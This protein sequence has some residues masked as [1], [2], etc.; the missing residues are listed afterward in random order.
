MKKSIIAIA[1]AALMLFVGQTASAQLYFGGSLG[2]TSTTRK[3]GQATQSGASFKFLPEVG[4]QINDRMSVGGVVGY[5]SGYAALGS[6][7]PTDLKSIATAAVSTSVDLNSDPN[8]LTVPGQA[9]NGGGNRING[10]RIAP[11]FRFNIF[12][13]RRFDFFVEGV[14]ALNSITMK[15]YDGQQWQTGGEYTLIEFGAKPGFKIKFDNH[16]NI[17]GRLG[18][19]GVQSLSQKDVENSITRVGFDMESANILLG[20]VY[21][22]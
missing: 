22:L 17:I 3:A 15:N 14:A 8:G 5:M 10:I 18:S 16:F 4:Y 6:F 7:D 9:G 19:L 21:V 20:F 12:S 13:G 2:F 1:A 11:Y